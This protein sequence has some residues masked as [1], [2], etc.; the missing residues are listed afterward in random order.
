MNAPIDQKQSTKNL[1]ARRSGKTL[2]VILIAAGALL[3]F[4]IIRSEVK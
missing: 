2:G 3:I 1:I 4:T